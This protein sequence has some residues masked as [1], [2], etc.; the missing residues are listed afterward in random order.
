M[1]SRLTVVLVLAL[2][3]RAFAGDPKAEAQA[4]VHASEKLFQAGKYQDAL[5]ELTTAYALDPQPGLLYAIAQ[6]HVKLGECAEAITWYQRFLD[7]HPDD[8]PAKAAHEA[9][10]MCTTALPA[11]PEPPPPPQPTVQQPP[12][13]PQQPRPA[14]I[15][16]PSSPTWYSSVVADALVIG[17]GVSGVA[18]I[19]LYLRALDDFDR[20]K[21]ANSYA[22]NHELVEDGH[23]QRQWAVIA[24]TG[25][26]MLVG[27]GLAYYFLHV[28][29][30][31]PDVMVSPTTNGG[32]VTWSG[33]F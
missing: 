16:P 30:Q 31:E 28:R 11:Q 10:D 2:A 20:A 8:R 1:T 21:T 29:K 7:T 6:V 12:L 33:R 17:G 19:E 5:G 9:I 14:P 4:H 32:V 15:A 26:V 22:R 3:S 18:G 27:G 13:P 23:S 24:G 25:G